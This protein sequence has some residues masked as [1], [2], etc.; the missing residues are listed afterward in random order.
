MFGLGLATTVAPLTATVLGS[1][2]HGHA[3]VA[4]GVN[5]AVARVAGLLAIAA[6]GAVVAGELRRRGSTRLAHAAAERRPLGRRSR[7]RA[8]AR[9]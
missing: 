5:N 9:S 8:R 1:V 7:A 4:S 3:G 6:L 2:E